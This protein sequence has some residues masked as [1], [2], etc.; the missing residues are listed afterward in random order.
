MVVIKVSEGNPHKDMWI[1]EYWSPNERDTTDGSLHRAG[2]HKFKGSYHIICFSCS[3]LTLLVR[4]QKDIDIT[5]LRSSVLVPISTTRCRGFGSTSLP[6]DN[7]LVNSQY[8]SC[9]ISRQLDGR[10]LGDQ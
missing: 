5:L 2:K 7:D 9:R 3:L 8:R 1:R 4:T 6:S 10:L